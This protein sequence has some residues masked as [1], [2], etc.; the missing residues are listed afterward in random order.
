MVVYAD[1]PE[2]WPGL[3][4]ALYGNLSAQVG[5]GERG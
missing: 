1:Y 3:M 5:A 2:R 4:E